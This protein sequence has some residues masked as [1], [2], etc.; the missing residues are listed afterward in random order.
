MNSFCKGLA[1]G[2]FL[3]LVFYIFLELATNEPAS[4]DVTAPPTNRQICTQSG[5]AFVEGLSSD[6]CVWLK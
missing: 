2:A 4:K 5:G 1:T 3:V 6:T